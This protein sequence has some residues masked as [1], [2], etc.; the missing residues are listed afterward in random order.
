VK[1]FE[2]SRRSAELMA[3]RR[4]SRVVSSSSSSSTAKITPIE[5]LNTS[6]AAKDWMR[7]MPIRQSKPSGAMSGSMAWPAR[8][9]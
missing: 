7:P 6:R 2:P 3:E 8:P 5:L 1:S 9:A 4:R